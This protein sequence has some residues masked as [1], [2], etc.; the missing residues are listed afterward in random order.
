M[1]LWFLI[2]KDIV[3]VNVELLEIIYEWFINQIQINTMDNKLKFLS[4]CN[5]QTNDLFYRPK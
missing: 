2:K 4:Y 1:V 3:T 5:T